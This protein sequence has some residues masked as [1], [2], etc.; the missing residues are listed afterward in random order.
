[1]V[2]LFPLVPSVETTLITDCHR[3]APFRNTP[4]PPVS[5]KLSG[6]TISE[7]ARAQRLTRLAPG[8]RALLGT[9]MSL[10]ATTGIT[11]ALGIA[12]WWVAAH[13][14][15][16]AAVGNGSAAVSAMTLAGTLG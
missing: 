1:M 3:F 9:F 5:L 8:Q 7:R 14:T 4:W 6:M 2:R 15:P 11:S 12:Y 10:I 16:M 13:R